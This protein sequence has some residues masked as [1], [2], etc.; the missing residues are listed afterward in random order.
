VSGLGDDK[1]LIAMDVNLGHLSIAQRALD[2]KSVKTISLRKRC[3]FLGQ[4]LRQADPDEIAWLHRNRHSHPSASALAFAI[5]IE[6]R[7][8][9]VIEPSRRKS[10]VTMFRLCRFMTA[11]N[12]AAE[13]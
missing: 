3:H 9:R 2:C 6:T 7:A 8:T 4:W 10:G 13:A 5:S 1:K 12:G 11:K